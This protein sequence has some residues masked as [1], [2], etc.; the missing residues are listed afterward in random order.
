MGCARDS[1]FIARGGCATWLL[2]SFCL[3]AAFSWSCYPVFLSLHIV[4]R[5]PPLAYGAPQTTPR[6]TAWAN[7]PSTPYT[8]S[9]SVSHTGLFYAFKITWQAAAP[10]LEEL[11]I[12]G[13]GGVF[14]WHEAFQRRE[15]RTGAGWPQLRV[16]ECGG[17]EVPSS[18]GGGTAGF[19]PSFDAPRLPFDVNL[20]AHSC[21][22]C[23]H[24]RPSHAMHPRRILVC[25]SC[26]R[27]S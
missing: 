22:V 20:H 9:A 5:A 27:T 8:A 10:N 26:H 2:S 23:L 4:H 3:A 11:R 14:G 6:S 1:G 17:G 16:L 7:S 24:A 13:L 12:N 21:H 19:F 15:A 25:T 18:T